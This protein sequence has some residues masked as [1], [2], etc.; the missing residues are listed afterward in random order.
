MHYNDYIIRNAKL[1]DAQEISNL[2]NY[3]AK[4]NLMLPKNTESIIE[5][6][7]DFIVAEKEGKIIG[8][9]AVTFFTEKLA[10]IRSLAVKKEY[11]GKG[12]GR[13]LVMNAEKILKEEGIEIVFALT[14]VPNFFLSMGYTIVDKEHFPQKIWRDCLGCPKIMKCDEVAVQKKL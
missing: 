1:S 3:Y 6:I 8:S 4:E 14:L 12:I 7:R 10:E 5:R 13:N 2:I 11:Q 9:C